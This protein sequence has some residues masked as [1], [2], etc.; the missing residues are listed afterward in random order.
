MAQS[1]V[2]PL[3]RNVL[4]NPMHP[5]FDEVVPGTIRAFVFDRQLTATA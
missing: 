2:N 4:I 5:D 3:E 1:A